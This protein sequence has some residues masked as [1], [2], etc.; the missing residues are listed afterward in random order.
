MSEEH[1]SESKI[2]GISNVSAETLHRIRSQY[3]IEN[4]AFINSLRSFQIPRGEVTVPYHPLRQ[5]DGHTC[6]FAAVLGLKKGYSL[7]TDNY[8]RNFYQQAKNFGVTTS[9]GRAKTVSDE[10]VRRLE[11][12]LKG[13]NVDL[14][15][16]YRA[17]VPAPTITHI[18]DLISTE[19][20]LILL[21]QISPRLRR[22]VLLSYPIDPQN[23]RS[24]H[25]VALHGYQKL[26]DGSLTF[27]VGNSLGG[28]HER[29]TDNQLADKLHA[30]KLGGFPSTPQLAVISLK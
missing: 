19:W 10:D 29:W 17:A 12:F 7:F 24:H 18:R 9:E 16:V 21:S 4:A 28:L 30:A 25:W 22:C 11:E 8:A 3:D 23:S 5:P 2:V 13:W 6:F 20:P 26:P 14:F 15:A 27:S 1:R